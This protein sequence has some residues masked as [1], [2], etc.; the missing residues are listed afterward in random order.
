MGMRIKNKMGTKVNHITTYKRET[1]IP[2]GIR[3]NFHSDEV[4]I[5]FLI[6][7]NNILNTLMNDK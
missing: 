5:H 6:P 2:I 3:F 1:K 4:F 7:K